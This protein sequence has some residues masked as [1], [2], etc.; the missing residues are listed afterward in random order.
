MSTVTLCQLGRSTIIENV[1]ERIRSRGPEIDIVI[2]V[3]RKD[4]PCLSL[5][6]ASTLN[7]LRH[8]I[9]KIHVIALERPRLSHGLHFGRIVFWDEREV[10][11]IRKAAINYRPEGVDR[12][13][14]LFQQLLKLACDEFCECDHILALDADTVFMRTQRLVKKGRSVLNVSQERHEPYYR[15]VRKLL[16]GIRIFPFSFVSHHM[17]FTKEYLRGLKQ[18]LQRSGKRWFEA[19]LDAVELEEMSGF[20]EYELYGNYVAFRH[21][22]S[23]LIEHSLNQSFASRRIRRLWHIKLRHPLIKSAS[24]HC[25]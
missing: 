8:R 21:P 18:E 9:R 5:T 1:G 16:P 3:T 23:V 20:S 24:F 25:R 2:P 11:P 15:V 22:Q 19:I 7:K 6:I 12:A 10:A 4:W 17:L 13:G 14:W